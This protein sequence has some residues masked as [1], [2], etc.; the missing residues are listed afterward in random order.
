[1]HKTIP[2]TFQALLL[3]FVSYTEPQKHA[4]TVD[5]KLQH[6]HASKYSCRQCTQMLSFPQ[7]QPDIADAKV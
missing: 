1:M 3:D 4:Y 5:G 7:T 6:K 2:S